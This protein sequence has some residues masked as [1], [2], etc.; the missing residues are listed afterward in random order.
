MAV[1]FPSH[2]LVQFN[3][4]ETRWRPGEAGKWGP[5]DQDGSSND[6]Q[7]MQAICYIYDMSRAT[8]SFDRCRRAASHVRRYLPANI[9]K[10]RFSTFIT[11][12]AVWTHGYLLPSRNPH[13]TLVARA[14]PRPRIRQPCPAATL[15]S[16]SS[17]EKGS[18][19]GRI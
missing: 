1:A 11:S 18:K 15:K 16:G 9:L 7:A 3:R 8:L 4:F 10:P 17:V 19:G 13:I 2:D 5:Q 6:M 12:L 14:S